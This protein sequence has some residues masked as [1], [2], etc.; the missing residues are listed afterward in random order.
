MDGQADLSLLFAHSIWYISYMQYICF[1][2]GASSDFR[3]A[4]RLA[5]AMVKQMGMSEKVSE[6][7]RRP[8]GEFSWIFRAY[9]DS[10][11]PDQ[12]IYLKV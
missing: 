8:L 5:T 10:G 9:S 3:T 4:T 2:V 7:L 12:L 6:H 11:G 1:T